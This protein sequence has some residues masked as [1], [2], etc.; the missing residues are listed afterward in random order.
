MK[1]LVLTGA[2]FIIPAPLI[3]GGNDLFYADQCKPPLHND[4]LHDDAAALRS[5]MAAMPAGSTMTL[6]GTKVYYFGSHRSSDAD[7][8]TNK[9]ELYLRSQRALNLD[10]ATVKQSDDEVAAGAAMICA[11]SNNQN[12]PAE[13]PFYPVNQ[14][15][16]GA[17]SLTTLV[18]ADAGNFAAG[19]FGYIDCGANA[20]DDDVDIGWFEAGP[21][22]GNPATGTIPLVYPLLK[23]YTG[24]IDS[25]CGGRTPRIFNYT[26]S[27]GPSQS[28][29]GGGP[30]ATDISIEN[31][32]LING[33]PAI[34]SPIVLTGT[35]NA[36]V[37]YINEPESGAQFIFG[38]NN[39]L[40]T[41]IHDNISS[42][43]CGG[44]TNF[45]PGEFTSSMNVIEYS[46]SQLTGSGCTNG[47]NGTPIQFERA[48][49]D[50]EGDEGNVYLNDTATILRGGAPN[51]NS[52][53]AYAVNSWGDTYAN[54]NCTSAYEGFADAGAIG[55]SG[56]TVIKNSSFTCT[57]SAPCITLEEPGDSITHSMITAGTSVLPIYLPTAAVTLEGNTIVAS[58]SVPTS[59]G[60]L[61][62]GGNQ[63]AY[64]SIIGTNTF[65][66][67]ATNCTG[68]IG[69]EL[70]PP[71][72]GWTEGGLIIATQN[73][74][75]Y[76]TKI[77][78]DASLSAYPNVVVSSQ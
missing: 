68:G 57:G 49:G 40:S 11:G 6:D 73:M 53:C 44:D 2:L 10:G 19:D 62:L 72:G 26:T 51:G 39:H 33:Q 78:Y 28:N 63:L 14:T 1:S 55:S 65:I 38:N 22:G 12:T 59:Y 30:L 17:N 7:W 3:A 35:V 61:Y 70:A 45:N 36:Q 77:K 8:G 25:Q 60:Q 69:I 27:P 21:G 42:T 5:C 13:G 48:F 24:T 15:Q 34:A 9:C 18:P 31:G 56:A 71:V 43:G 46:T 23:P 20:N 67:Q 76:A 32:T 4:G 58:G 50:S 41:F 74:Q 29:P 47:T 37:D 52:P 16:P 75:G 66:C 54:L 64:S